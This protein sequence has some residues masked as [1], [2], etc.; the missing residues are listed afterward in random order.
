[1]DELTAG[2]LMS[3]KVVTV[4]PTATVVDAAKLML[5]HRISGLPV[6]DEMRKLVGVITE[7]DLLQRIEIGTDD[8]NPV[9]FFGL[10]VAQ[11]FIKEHG[12]YVEDVMTPEVV[13][14]AENTPLAEIAGLLHSKRLKRVPVTNDGHVVGVV[15]RADILRVLIS[16]P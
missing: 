16:A 6:V 9:D 13:T 11:Q 5:E 15:S 14:V 1:M 7:G 2:D 12:R 10:E 3:T 4:S 8:E